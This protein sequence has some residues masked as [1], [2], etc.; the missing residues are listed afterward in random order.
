MRV[1]TV[2][3]KRRAIVSAIKDILPNLN[4]RCCDVPLVNLETF[5]EMIKLSLEEHKLDAK[6]ITQ[7][8]QTPMP[9][10]RDPKGRYYD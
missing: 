7:A 6:T 2:P 10:E 1:I 5:A 3:I 4:E 8:S 9:P